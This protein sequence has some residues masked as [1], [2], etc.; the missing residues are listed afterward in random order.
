MVVA[1]GLGLTLLATVTLLDR[2]ISAQVKDSLPGTAPTF[3]FVDIQPD[4]IA[5]FNKDI[6]RFPTATG[7]KRT[8]MIRGRITALNGVAAKDAK[9]ASSARWAL[10]GDRGITYASAP[11]KG[12]DIT[13][14]KWWPANY[15]GAYAH[16]L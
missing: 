13:E 5:S 8:P 3:F 12:A 16:L 9:V 10:N 7:Y 4:E 15:H 14:G 11:S 2:T 6:A 1:L